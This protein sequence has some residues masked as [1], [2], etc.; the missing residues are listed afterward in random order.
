[1]AKTPEGRVK[2]AIKKYLTELGVWFAGRPQPKEVTGWM[3]MPVSMTSLG[4]N[5]IPDFCGIY[6]GRPLYIEA[7]APGG[8]VSE[9]QKQRIAEIRAAGGLAL[10]VASVE[11]LELALRMHDL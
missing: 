2:D 11:E 8:K 6:K 9:L 4:V 7:K 3:Y 10:V 5:G 1:M